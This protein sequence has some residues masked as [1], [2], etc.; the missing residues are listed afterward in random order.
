MIPAFVLRHSLSSNYLC[1]TR[2]AKSLDERL[3]LPSVL[4]FTECAKSNKLFLKYQQIHFQSRS[5]LCPT[6]V[7][8]S[9]GIVEEMK[10][11]FKGLLKSADLC[12]FK[13]NPELYVAGAVLDDIFAA[14][15]AHLLLSLRGQLVEELI[16][17]VSEAVMADLWAYHRMCKFWD[18]FTEFPKGVRPVSTTWPWSIKPSLAVLWGVCWMFYPGVHQQPSEAG[19][20]PFLCPPWPAYT[21]VSTT[22]TNPIVAGGNFIDD[23]AGS[24]SLVWEDAQNSNACKSP[25][26]TCYDHK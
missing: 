15:F 23:P 11:A 7:A 12:C 25:S 18:W 26:L 8:Q 19:F 5:R 21:G 4:S 22:T 16:R 20:G 10:D 3:Q 24:D 6:D 17:Q 14:N 1:R 2:L 13:S 9:L